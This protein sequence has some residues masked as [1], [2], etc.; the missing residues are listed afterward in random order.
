MLL[1]DSYPVGLPYFNIPLAY[2]VFSYTSYTYVYNT[3]GEAVK[4]F[5]SQNFFGILLPMGRDD[6]GNG[7]SGEYVRDDK[8]L[9]VDGK[10]GIYDLYEFEEGMSISSATEKYKILEK[11]DYGAFAPFR[12]YIVRKE[13]L[14]A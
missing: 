4:T 2:Q 6:L 7:L 3:K 13:K 10:S 8:K 12:L 11:H 9:Y 1:L 14:N 5:A